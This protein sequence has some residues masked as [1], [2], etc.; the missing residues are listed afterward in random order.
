MKRSIQF[1]SFVFIAIVFSVI[2]ASAQSSQRFDADIPFEFSVG[3]HTYAAGN[4]NVRV[5]KQGSVAVLTLSDSTGKQLERIIVNPNGEASNDE[6]LF[7]FVREGDQRILTKVASAEVGFDIPR[8][9]RKQK[10]LIATSK[11]V[12]QPSPGL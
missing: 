5:V 7:T 6:S 4:Y 9:S 8:T 10:A 2:S 12:A 3:G 1:I 11:N